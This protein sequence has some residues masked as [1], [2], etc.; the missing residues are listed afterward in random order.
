MELYLLRH[1][2]AERG[3][4][5]EADSERALTEQG[6]HEIRRVVAAAK[7]AQ[8][9]PSVVL[10]SPYKRARQTAR[11]AADLLD[12]SSPVLASDALMPDANPR[13]L[14]EE[15]RT[16][17]SEAALLLAGHEPLF[18][19]ATAYLLGCPELQVSF[20]KAGL[21]RIDM[22]RFGPEPRGILRWMLTPHLTV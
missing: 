15:I 12:C 10:S 8:A 20:P 4:A 21:V 13:A 5:G 9:C 17:R 6:E 18:S 2:S 14:W 3:V 1:G 19:A 16:H 11:I 7:L 22:D